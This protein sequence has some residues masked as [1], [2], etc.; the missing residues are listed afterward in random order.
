M[1]QLSAIWDE[2]VSPVWGL[3]RKRQQSCWIRQEEWDGHTPE[4][5]QIGVH[6]YGLEYGRLEGRRAVPMSS[7]MWELKHS[8]ALILEAMGTW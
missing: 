6:H 4:T 7:L 3:K 1:F 8:R 5:G 2:Q